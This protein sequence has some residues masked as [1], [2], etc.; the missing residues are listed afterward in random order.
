MGGS[1]E[2]MANALGM[3]TQVLRPTVKELITAKRVKA[4]GRARGMRY[5]A[6]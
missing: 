2:D 1:S 6:V 3:D 4:K 5:A